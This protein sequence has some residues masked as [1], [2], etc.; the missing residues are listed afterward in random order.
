MYLLTE[1]VASQGSIVASELRAA[2]KKVLF[3][4]IFLVEF[5]LPLKRSTSGWP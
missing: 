4:R 1:P 5:L 3:S 2:V